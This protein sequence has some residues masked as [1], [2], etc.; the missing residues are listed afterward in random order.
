MISPE[1]LYI[2]D[3]ASLCVDLFRLGG[4]N[5][6]SFGHDRALVDCVTFEQNGITVVVANKQG[7]SAF[8]WLTPAMKAPGK[9]VWRIPKGTPLPIEIV[10]V[11]DLTPGKRGHYH[12]APVQ[13]M[14]LTKYLGLLEEIGIKSVKLTAEEIQR[15]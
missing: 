15:G 14:P 8:D 4:K 9:H 13:N 1:N 2:M 7:F 10:L 6:N 5:R 12:F 11:K 3:V